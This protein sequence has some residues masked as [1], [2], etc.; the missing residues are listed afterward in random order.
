MAIDIFGAQSPTAMAS[1]VYGTGGNMSMIPQ[2][3]MGLPPSIGGF[4]QARNAAFDQM[5]AGAKPGVDWNKLLGSVMGAMKTQPYSYTPGPQ[6][7][8]GGAKLGD[9]PKARNFAQM[10]AVQKAVLP[11]L[12][13]LLMAGR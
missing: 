1:E 10:P 3:D 13:Q 12:A 2:G 6:A 5:V 9:A 4:S 8:G 7:P 11:S